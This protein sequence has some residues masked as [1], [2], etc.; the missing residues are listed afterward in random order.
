MASNGA[1]AIAFFIF[2]MTGMM[3]TTTA[4]HTWT[5]VRNTWIG[6]ARFNHAT[7]YSFSI[8][9]LIP[10]NVHEVLIYARVHSGRSGLHQDL[11]IK[12]FTQIGV[13]QYEKYLF[14]AQW[15]QD[16]LTTSTDNMWFPMPPNRRI[17]INIP[18]IRYNSGAVYLSAIG[19]R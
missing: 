14:V 13:T 2:C 12:I 9:S 6:S 16:A 7:T 11:D 4:G 15:P 10:S 3:H 8:P 18:A 19:Y 1:A 5:S 17:Y